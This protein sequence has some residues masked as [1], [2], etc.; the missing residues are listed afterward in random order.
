MRAGQCASRACARSGGAAA[1]MRS[2]HAPLQQPPL[3][4]QYPL[5]ALPLCLRSFSRRVLLSPLNSL[6]PLEP[7]IRLLS[8]PVFLFCFFVCFFRDVASLFSSLSFSLLLFFT[9][10][11]SLSDQTAS[12]SSFHLI[13][14]HILCA[15]SNEV[16]SHFLYFS[17]Y[18]QSH[19]S[20][21][22]KQ[23]NIKTPT[24]SDDHLHP[25]PC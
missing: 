23:I 4:P 7:L 9:L 15:N 13:V 16:V 19:F 18:D 24:P 6:C 5:C 20:P 12:L 17:L 21:L 10:S 1:C 25:P 14:L 3:S 8:L 2:A 22:T 11:F